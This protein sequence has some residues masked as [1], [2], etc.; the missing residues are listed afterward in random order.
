MSNYSRALLF[1]LLISISLP[2][3]SFAI[4]D[5]ISGLATGAGDLVKG[6][7]QKIGIG[8]PTTKTDQ[9]VTLALNKLLKNSNVA[10]KLSKKAKAIL[11]FPQIVK[12]GLGIGGHYGEGALRKE[13]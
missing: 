11:V 7:G 3:Q 6:V 2:Y 4:G 12:A 10:N 13:G 9:D 8:V 1:A 5:A